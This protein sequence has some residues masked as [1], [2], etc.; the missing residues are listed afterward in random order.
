MQLLLSDRYTKQAGL[1]GTVLL[2]VPTAVAREVDS[3]IAG[4]T[5]VGDPIFLR[6]GMGTADTNRDGKAAPA[7]FY[8]S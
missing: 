5:G 8:P 6:N 4:A 1:E 7:V 3:P 2:S